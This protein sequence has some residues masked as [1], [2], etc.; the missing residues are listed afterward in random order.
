M[1]S[2]D[3]KIWSYVGVFVIALCLGLCLRFGGDK[4]TIKRLRVDLVQAQS[5]VQE[6]RAELAS[7]NEDKRLAQE[8][9]EGVITELESSQERGHRMEILINELSESFRESDRAI[10]RGADTIDEL[11]RLY[12]LIRDRLMVEPSY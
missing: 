4:Y 3:K 1:N 9:V 7:A 5:G 10:R 11:I 2:L 8:R 12:E 6:V